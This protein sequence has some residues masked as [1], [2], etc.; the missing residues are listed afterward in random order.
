MVA[1]IAD[2]TRGPFYVTQ[3]GRSEWMAALQL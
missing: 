2:S 3:S 1:H